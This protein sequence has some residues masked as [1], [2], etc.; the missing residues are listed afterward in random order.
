VTD[1]S[2]VAERGRSTRP[3]SG[4][5][6]PASI[7]GTRLAAG[8]WAGST[9]YLYLLP[10]LLIYAAFFLYPFVRLVELSLFE[11]N[12]IAPRVWVGAGNYLKML[13]DPLFWRAFNNNLGWTLG[14][15]SVPVI[16]GLLLAILLVRGPLPGRTLFR[17]LYFMPQVLSSVVVAVIWSWIYNPTFGALNSFLRAVGLGE[18]QRGWLGDPGFA[19][20]ALF[21]A[22]TW[23]TY[24]FN[25]V[26]FI[27]ALQ[28]I[29]ET[30][31]DAAKV[32]GA[33]AWQQ[34]WYVLLPFL[35]G[36]L[37]T[38][39]LL[40]MIWSF[41]VFDLVYILTRGGPANVTLVLPMYLFQSAFEFEKVGYGSAIS[42]ALGVIVVL[43]SLVFLKRQGLIAES[44]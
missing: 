37:A 16:I 10:A 19:M 17:T 32:D 35:R 38:V 40:S 14:A 30:Y 5:T 13:D 8:R 23:V 31:F 6:L 33:T 43:L 20:P 41:Q 15:M 25:M 29:D 36:P 22:W 21:V 18:W 26:I 34:F 27:A 1:S 12:G 24:G 39:T 4:A 11:W 7:L 42:V 2:R 9:G 44:A 28:G 3:R